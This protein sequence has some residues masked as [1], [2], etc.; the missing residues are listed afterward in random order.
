MEA[1]VFLSE[2]EMDCEGENNNHPKIL[3]LF[4]THTLLAVVSRSER[5]QL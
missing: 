1:E 5:I 4:L 3:S 2:S